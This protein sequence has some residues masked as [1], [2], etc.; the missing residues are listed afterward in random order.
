MI[1]P[2]IH[3]S[4]A[5]L[6]AVPLVPRL[7]THS[8]QPLLTPPRVSASSRIVSAQVPPTRP[9]S[10]AS[11]SPCTRLSHTIPTGKL[12]DI[13][14]VSNHKRPTTTAVV[15]SSKSSFAS[16]F[17]IRAPRALLTATD[18]ALKKTL[19]YGRERKR[20]VLMERK[21]DG[22]RGTSAGTLKPR[23]LRT[24]PTADHDAQ[25]VN[26]V[27]SRLIARAQAPAPTAT[28]LASTSRTRP[29]SALSQTWKVGG[30]AGE[31]ELV[32]S[33]RH[34]VL[35]RARPASASGPKPTPS[36]RR[37]DVLERILRLR[38]YR[39]GAQAQVIDNAAPAPAP[40]HA[41]IAP[42]P[43]THP[44]RLMSKSRTQ[45]HSIA[46]CS[47]SRSRMLGCAARRGPQDYNNWS[48]KHGLRNECTPLAHDADNFLMHTAP[49]A[50]AHTELRV[51]ERESQSL[52]AAQGHRRA[53]RGHMQRGLVDGEELAELCAHDDAYA[54]PV[55]QYGVAP[56]AGLR[57][58]HNSSI[59][60][61][62]AFPSSDLSSAA[63]AAEAR[64]RKSAIL[65]FEILAGIVKGAGYRIGGSAESDPPFLTPLKSSPSARAVRCGFASRTVLQLLVAPARHRV[66]YVGRRGGGERCVADVARG[67]W[68]EVV[69]FSEDS[70]SRAV[71]SGGTWQLCACTSR[72]A[73]EGFRWMGACLKTMILRYLYRARRRSPR[74]ARQR[75]ERSRPTYTV[76]VL[77]YPFT[78]LGDQWKDVACHDDH[79]RGVG[80]SDK[81]LIRP[82]SYKTNRKFPTGDIELSAEEMSTLTAMAEAAAA[83][84]KGGRMAG[85]A[86]ETLL[87]G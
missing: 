60:S 16:K 52:H 46:H 30:Q 64:L 55:A 74:W 42:Q 2:H 72:S 47:R 65:H 39:H 35:V 75:M 14:I 6:H 81:P 67:P 53:R 11:S 7:Q 80:S 61:R 17:P 19:R 18:S 45:L 48:S 54:V 15:L 22:T 37:S 85:G 82:A 41:R 44:P 70:P 63:A 73:R 66:E 84:L 36:S 8:A 29:C 23:A 10:N 26:D 59:E 62:L 58:A 77:L 27:V 32:R 5:P 49:H 86:E 87:L 79:R 28:R 40:A 12:P 33:P 69:V 4:C 20:G 38:D 68:V 76:R 83:N 13:H 43:N 31:A 24:C 50:E 25:D 57:G 21:R 34:G 9:E 51:R 78:S 1:C 3:T 56:S 71:E